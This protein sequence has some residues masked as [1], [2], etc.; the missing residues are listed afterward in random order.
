MFFLC[1]TVIT[2]FQ[3][4]TLKNYYAHHVACTRT[5]V[6]VCMCRSV[7]LA[8]AVCTTTQKCPGQSQ[9]IQGITPKLRQLLRNLLN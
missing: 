9:G 6:I 3:C 1:V 5:H 7:D 2:I 8:I 4:M